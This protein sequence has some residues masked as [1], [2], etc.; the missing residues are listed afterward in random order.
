MGPG[1]LFLLASSR[2][3]PASSLGA[4]GGARPCGSSWNSAMAI[5]RTNER[6]WF[7]IPFRLNV[8]T[9]VSPGGKASSRC[10]TLAK[11]ESAQRLSTLSGFL[12][13]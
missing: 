10:C 12:L 11:G 7:R 9:A 3:P 8:S 1:G 4:F 6:R 2:R 5:K 13:V